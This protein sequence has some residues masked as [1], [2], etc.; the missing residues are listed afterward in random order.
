MIPGKWGM[1]VV[2]CLCRGWSAVG[3]DIGRMG[4]DGD[5]GSFLAAIFNLL[6]IATILSYRGPLE[7]CSE[8][9][10][11]TLDFMTHESRA[12]LT[13]DGIPESLGYS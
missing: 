8:M 13:Q 10:C 7:S 1:R 2:R 12:S 5:K 4:R 6:C 11:G 3:G 9:I